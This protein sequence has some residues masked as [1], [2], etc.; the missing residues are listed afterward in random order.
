MPLPDGGAVTVSLG[1]VS[2]PRVGDAEIVV[3]GLGPNGDQRWSREITSPLA[4]ADHHVTALCVAPNGDVFVAGSAYDPT[5]PQLAVHSF[6]AASNL[7][8]ASTPGA[9]YAHTIAVAPSG[10]VHLGGQN[11]W[12]AS[13][14]FDPLVVSLRTDG[15]IALRETEGSG[16]WSAVSHVRVNTAGDVVAVASGRSSMLPFLLHLVRVG[17]SP[18]LDLGV[19]LAS[20][21]AVCDLALTTNG[22]ALIAV[23]DGAPRV[24]HVAAGTNVVSTWRIPGVPQGRI[25]AIAVTNDGGAFVAGVTGGPGAATFDAR[26]DPNGQVL[27]SSL[28]PGFAPPS[29]NEHTIAG[30]FDLDVALDSRGNAFVS[31]SRPAPGGAP[32]TWLGVAKFVD[33][34]PIGASYCGPAVPNSTGVSGSIAA[35]G[36]DVRS[37]DNITL[38]ASGLPGGTFGYSLVSPL[39]AFVAQPGGSQGNLCLGGPIGRY[40]GPAGV[41]LV[42]TDGTTSLQLDLDT[43][44]RPTGPYSAAAGETWNFQCRHRDS[45]GGQAVSNSTDGLQLALL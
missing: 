2:T 3:L 11:D 26:F 8:W 18:W 38:L 22:D 31:S 40:V 7:R 33:G 21:I 10:W 24:L 32:G 28:R 13:F 1:W 12:F 44:P 14:E 9:G 16:Q 41:R 6:D 15:S 19:S 39:Q 5:F 20:V 30:A 34:G 35:L 4:L 37:D 42:R 36:S 43:L 25:H 23:D 27:W 17:S 45:V 29:A